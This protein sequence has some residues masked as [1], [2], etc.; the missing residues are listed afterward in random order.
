MN[1]AITLINTKL[2]EQTLE[3]VLDVYRNKEYIVFVDTDETAIMK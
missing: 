2:L 3:T 1:E